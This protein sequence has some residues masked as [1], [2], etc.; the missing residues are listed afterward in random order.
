MLPRMKKRFSVLC[1]LE[2]RSPVE[3]V[4]TSNLGLNYKA[5]PQNPLRNYDRYT[6]S[7][8]E[9]PDKPPEDCPLDRPQLG[10]NTWSFLHTMAAYYPDKP[11]TT[12]QKD[13]NN[14]LQ[15][16]SKVFPCYECAED[17]KENIK[18]HPPETSSQQILSKWLC[19]RHNDV[20]KKLGKPIFDCRK[21]NERW[22]DGWKDG[23]CD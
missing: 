18:I 20:N 2:K 13:M 4:Q 9:V 7:L 1:K 11:S 16:F 12:E 14:F 15:L 19:E 10:R 3:H 6:D 23:S 17:F 22:R 21:V 8:A 5:N